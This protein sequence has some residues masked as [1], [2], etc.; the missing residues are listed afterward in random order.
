MN[1]ITTHPTIK[2]LVQIRA[3]Y[4]SRTEVKSNPNGSHAL[5]QIRDFNED[6]TEIDLDNIT[7]IEPGAIS[8]DQVLRNGDVIF[9][10][11]GAKNFGFAPSELPEPALVASYFFILRPS[12]DLAPDYLAWFLN[13]ETTKKLLRKYATQGAHMPVVRRDVLENLKIPLPDLCTQHKIVKI[14]TLSEH[15]SRLMAELTEKKK[16]FVNAVCLRAAQ[17]S[18]TYKQP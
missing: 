12:H 10:S 3:G 15:R 14:A 7:R 5:L 13:L 4:Q 11:K 6:R 17:E 9:L 8:Q 18:S 16:N 2:D 1:L